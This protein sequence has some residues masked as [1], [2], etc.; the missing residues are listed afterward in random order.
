MARTTDTDAVTN[1]LTA[2]RAMTARARL[3]A[4]ETADK[5]TGA[6]VGQAYDALSDAID[7]RA[8]RLRAAA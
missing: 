8:N 7:H 4:H 3:L 1:L 2:A 6:L 5:P